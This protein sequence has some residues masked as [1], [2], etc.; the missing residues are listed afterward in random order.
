MRQCLKKKKNWSALEEHLRFSFGTHIEKYERVI[1]YNPRGWEAEEIGWRVY[2]F[3]TSLSHIRKS[4]TCTHA[5]TTTKV[6][7]PWAKFQH[8]LVI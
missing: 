2:G 3:E 4:H 1:K 6:G 8:I 7:R 5:I